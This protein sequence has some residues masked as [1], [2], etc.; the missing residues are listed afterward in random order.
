MR[1]A[2]IPVDENGAVALKLPLLSVKNSVPWSAPAA[3]FVMISTCPPL[4][5][6][7]KEYSEEKRSG[8]VRIE[9]MEPLGGI[10]L[11]SSKPSTLITVDVGDPLGRSER[12][13][14]TRKIVGVVS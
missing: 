13:K 11:E 5:T 1:P 4:L 9:A 2:G 7:G 8:L 12:L 14:F 10:A 3:T 6:G